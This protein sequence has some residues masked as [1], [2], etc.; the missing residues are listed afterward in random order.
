[1]TQPVRAPNE[2]DEQ[3]NDYGLDIDKVSPPE[4][5]L[6]AVRRRVGGRYP[7]DPFGLD[8]QIADL[9]AP[10][11]RAVIRVHVTGADN[12][13]LDSGAV[14]VANRGFGIFEPLVLA[15]AVAKETGRRV[16][17]VGA[18]TTPFV[19]GAVRRL[20]AIADNARDLSNCV[21]AG[22][23]VS[24][25]LAPTWLRTG[26]GPPPLPLM[27]AMTRAPAI[28]VAVSPGGPFG[29]MVRPWRVRFGA[30]VELE[31]PHEPGDPLGAAQL[32]EAVRDAVQGLLAPPS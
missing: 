25:L 23:L 15:V 26:A 5:F 29:T 19:G 24:V 27:Q 14:L 31:Q 13:P 6:Q 4:P 8:P 11:A 7:T 20:G 21:R 10:L 16:R 2:H 17:V 22:H 32:A 3:E 18:P 28:P 12:V 30:P 9:A 1:M